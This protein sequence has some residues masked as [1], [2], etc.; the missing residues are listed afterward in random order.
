MG[1]P[2]DAPTDVITGLVPVMTI[3]RARLRQALFGETLCPPHRDGR[4]KPDMTIP[5]ERKSL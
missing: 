4:D 1:S 3:N 2:V 5:C